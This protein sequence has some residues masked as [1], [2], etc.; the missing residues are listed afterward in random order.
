MNPGD[1]VLLPLTQAA[2][3]SA[4]LRPTLFL[5]PLP[6]PYQT[7]LVCGLST[8]LH[9]IRPQWDELIQ[10]GDADFA[11]SGLRQPSVIRLSYL[12]AARPVEV[13]GIIGSVDAARVI[14]LRTQL[15]DFLRP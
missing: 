5:A 4:K 14:R 6:G 11:A 8:Q 9:S 10:P 1:V 12:R 15:A 3:G 2:G 13:Q 7:I